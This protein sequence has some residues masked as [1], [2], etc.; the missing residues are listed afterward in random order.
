MVSSVGFLADIGDGEVARQDDFALFLRQRFGD[1]L[2]MEELGKA[3]FGNLKLTVDEEVAW[4]DF[5]LSRFCWIHCSRSQLI[6]MSVVN[7]FDDRLLSRRLE[8][9]DSVP[10]ILE[11]REDDL[12]NA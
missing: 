12:A 2:K 9:N 11:L 1:V 5:E 8:N 4:A 3:N 6:E 10:N 7:V